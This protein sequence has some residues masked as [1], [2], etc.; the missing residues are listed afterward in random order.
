MTRYAREADKLFGTDITPEVL[1][2][3][4]PWSWAIDWFTNA[5]DV[6]SNV[7]DYVKYGLILKYGYIMETT[8]VKDTYTY[9]S[10]GDGTSTYP[11]DV[12]PLIMTSTV[13]KRRKANPFGFGVAWDGLS[14]FQ[15]AIAGALGLSKGT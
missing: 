11:V 6:L 12:P 8:M 3:L 14:P 15:L 9:V 2:E 7:S 10:Y 5:G 13:K 1:W 4:T